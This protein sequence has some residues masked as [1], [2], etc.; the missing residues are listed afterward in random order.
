MDNQSR[1]AKEYVYH[2]GSV[3]SYDAMWGM[4]DV[5]ID[6]QGQLVKFHIGVYSS[7]RPSRPPIVGERVTMQT[8]N[9][10][11]GEIAIVQVQRIDS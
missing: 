4:A 5:R 2:T 6:D 10:P 1:P 8:R 9:Q 3:V 7:G 11:N